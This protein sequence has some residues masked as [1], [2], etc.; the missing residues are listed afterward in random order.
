MVCPTRC[1]PVE[2]K[3]LR[4]KRGNLRRLPIAAQAASLPHVAAS[5]LPSHMDAGGV[6]YEFYSRGG[7]T[8]GVRTFYH[9]DG[10]AVSSRS[11]LLVDADPAVHELLRGVLKRE[12]RKIEDAYDGHEALDRIR[13]ATCDLVLAGPGRN[14]FDPLTLL[15][16]VH[17]IRPDLKVILTGDE[18]GPELAVSAIR[19]RAYS[20]FHKPLPPAP[21]ADMVQQAL[22]ST[23]WED[24]IR[25]ISARPE[26][27]M[28]EVRC[29]IAAAERITQFVRE[30]E[31]DLPPVVYDD[32]VAAFRELLLNAVEHGGNS[33]PRKSAQ[34]SIVR[35]SRALIV[36]IQDPG[37]GFSMDSLPHAAVSNPKEQPIKHVEVR[38]EKG[39]RPGGFGI[40]MTRNLVDEL[41]YNERGNAVLFVKYL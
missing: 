5:L 25:V 31:A 33:D 22:D 24:D 20:Y 23:S 21:L 29:K 26:W 12:D 37:Q 18:R 6:R 1:V 14:G 17:E 11:L 8:G 36:Q 15:R 34:V 4:G 27:I 3:G 39:Q 10:D 16:S 9:K 40:L 35:S 30:A 28:L 2:E 41:I 19:E 32:V 7:E 38:A 13:Q